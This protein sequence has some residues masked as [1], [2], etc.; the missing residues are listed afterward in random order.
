MFEFSTGVGYNRRTIR[1]SGKGGYWEKENGNLMTKQLPDDCK[2]KHSRLY[3]RSITA[4]VYFTFKIG[5]DKDRFTIGPEFIYNYRASAVTR[6]YVPGGDRVKHKITGL[7][8]N[9][10][11]VGLFV[12]TDWTGIPIYFR[13]QPANI[14]DGVKGPKMGFYSFGI[15]L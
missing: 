9:R 3:V 7:K 10:F 4:P 6:Y 14:F 15:M 1:A 8:P 11:C 13:W 5:K 12:S 2:L